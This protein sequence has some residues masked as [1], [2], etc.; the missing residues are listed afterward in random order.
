MPHKQILQKH[1]N[2]TL[3]VHHQFA[4]AFN[5]NYHVSVQVNNLKIPNL[6][7]RPSPQAKL[8]KNRW[9]KKCV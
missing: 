5:M 7:V 4:K 8:V 3:Q 9:C 1:T 6:T 2:E